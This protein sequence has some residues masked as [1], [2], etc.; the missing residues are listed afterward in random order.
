MKVKVMVPATSA[1]LGPGFDVLGIAVSLQNEFI[2]EKA[3]K[4]AI[5]LNGDTAI[6]N[7]RDNLFYK[8]FVF[9]FK[10]ANKKVP[11]VKIIMNLSIPPARGLG[12]SATAV[13]GG[14]VAANAL[15][16]GTFTREQLLAYALKLEVGNNPDNVAPA[17]L[18]G[19]VVLTK[20]KRDLYTVKLPIPSGIKAVYFIP[21]F[22]MDTITG[23]K[24]MPNE[25]TKE[26]VVFSTS[27]VALLLA[28]L[29]TKK[30]DLLRIAMQDRIH[31]PTRTKLFP[32]MPKLIK[33]ANDAGALG[34]ALSGGGS[35]IIALADKNFK[36][37]EKAM[38]TVGIKQRI[39]GTTKTLEIINEGATSTLL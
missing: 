5:V 28:A 13:V 36:E 24:L 22:A 9:L 7:S 39:T 37:I 18:G 23:R 15:L 16:K 1:N 17:L 30:Y 34:T 2:V 10:K 25:Y 27:R 6:T 19:L 20:D 33:A 3:N 11:Q 8:S 14:L 26:D 35:T 4:F 29:Q 32:V 21:D 31:Q 38:I 12:S